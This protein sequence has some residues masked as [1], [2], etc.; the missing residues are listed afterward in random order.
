MVIIYFIRFIIAISKFKNI[1][2]KG[3]E[4]IREIFIVSSDN[5]NEIIINKKNK[6]LV[7]KIKRFIYECFFENWTT[8]KTI[9]VK[10]MY[11]KLK[12]RPPDGIK[13]ATLE[14]APNKSV[15]LNNEANC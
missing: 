3:F 7:Y 12:K 15:K 8:I 5:L 9:P 10:R 11:V 13:L 14:K 6:G 1:A 2:S 4:K